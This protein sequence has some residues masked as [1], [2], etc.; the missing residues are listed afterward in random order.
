MTTPS[1]E[2]LQQTIDQFWEVVP[3]VWNTVRSHVRSTATHQFDIS[4]EQFHILRHIHKGSHSVSQLASV[5]RISRPAISQAV[6]AL[7]NKG[8][9]SRQPNTEDRRYIQLELTKDGSALLESIFNQ[10]R[11]WLLDRFS[12]IKTNEL[13][14]IISGLEHLKK[15]VCD[16]E[17]VGK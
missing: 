2:I 11:L 4:E 16:G 3:P 7:V 8:L 12:K 14:V 13:Q 6:D 1:T 5:G 15:A 10:A 17:C 9:V